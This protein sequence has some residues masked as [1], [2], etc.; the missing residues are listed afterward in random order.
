MKAFL[1]RARFSQ[2]HAEHASYLGRRIQSVR[3]WVPA[4]LHADVLQEVWEVVYRRIEDVPRDELERP[5][6]VGV[7]RFKLLHHARSHAR[8]RRRA[9][10]LAPIA[11]T[12][13]DDGARFESRHLLRRLLD[14]LPD[15]QSEVLVRSE[16]FGESSREIAARANVSPNTI[17]GRLR[18]ARARLGARA[19]SRVSDGQLTVHS[20]FANASSPMIA[21]RRGDT[22]SSSM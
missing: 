1:T 6:L 20:P 4:S 9:D 2:L 14:V 8:A 15:E 16:L 3:P 19:G 12:Q 7:M 22:D 10:A 17:S 5:W 18:L 13:G 11:A 21:W